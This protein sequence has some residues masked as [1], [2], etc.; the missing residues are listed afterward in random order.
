MIF[1]KRLNA[2]ID[3]LSGTISFLQEG[4]VVTNFSKQVTSI[5]RSLEEFLIEAGAVHSNPKK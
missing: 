2:K 4:D 5:C 1:E 3:Q